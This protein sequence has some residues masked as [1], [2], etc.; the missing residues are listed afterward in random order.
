MK[1]VKQAKKQLQQASRNLNKK[2]SHTRFVTEKNALIF[3]GVT[4]KQI[5]TW[6]SESLLA[7]YKNPFH[8]GYMYDLDELTHLIISCVDTIKI[9]KG[10]AIEKID[11]E[12]FKGK[13]SCKGSL[14]GL[15]VIQVNKKIQFN[16]GQRDVCKIFAQLTRRNKKSYYFDN[17]PFEIAH[18]IKENFEFTNKEELTMA[19]LSNAIE[20]RDF[21]DSISLTKSI[22]QLKTPA[23]KLI[24]KG[25]NNQLY[26][27]LK[28]LYI[29]PFEKSNLNKRKGI[30]STYNEIAAVIINNVDFHK[31]NPSSDNIVQKMKGN[32]FSKLRRPD[33]VF[34]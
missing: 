6:V 16:G 25:N 13:H 1:L 27:I 33:V 31:G 18:F 20:G 15:S 8:E 9:T 14:D 3:P 5:V 32:N 30:L 23:L 26:Y 2:V 7:V 34:P 11:P 17:T 29:K 12:T 10:E 19:Q 28:K 22:E 24:W 21:N 4:S